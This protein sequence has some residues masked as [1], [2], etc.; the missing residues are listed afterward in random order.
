M[1]D[2]LQLKIDPEAKLVMVGH[3]RRDETMAALA[4]EQLAAAQVR[5]MKDPGVT[6][7]RKIS[8]TGVCYTAPHLDALHDAVQ[9]PAGWFASA[10]HKAGMTVP[11]TSIDGEVT[12]HKDGRKQVV[13]PYD[14]REPA[15]LH[16]VILAVDKDGRLIANT[17]GQN[18][19]V[20]MARM[21]ASDRRPEVPAPL[22]PRVLQKL[23]RM[24]A[25]ATLQAS[26]NCPA[27][28]IPVSAKVAPIAKAVESSVATIA[29]R[30]A[31]A[32]GPNLWR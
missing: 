1:L 32:L 30:L 9:S 15:V 11:V 23:Q 17:L 28:S 26:R 6:K 3:Y 18:Q 14:G 27:T 22:D 25:K 16:K 8:L 29:Q 31:V 19:K 13:L 5:L 7:P 21:Q 4:P 10:L 20:A 2:P 24:S 12:V